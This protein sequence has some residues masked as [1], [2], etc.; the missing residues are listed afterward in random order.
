MCTTW[1]NLVI[2]LSATWY[3]LSFKLLLLIITQYYLGSLKWSVNDM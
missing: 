3:N 2:L 1:Y